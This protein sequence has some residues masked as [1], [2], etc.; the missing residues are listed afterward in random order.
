[1]WLE[2]VLI[3]DE[4]LNA[5]GRV[6][7]M[8]YRASYSPASRLFTLLD[9][10]Q[11]R[12]GVSAARLAER[13]EVEARSVRRYI[14]MLQDMGIPVEG[15]RGRYGGYRLC[16]SYK[17]PPLM[18]T[19]EEALAVTLGLQAAKQLGMSDAIPT[20]ESALAK[21]ER[22][23]PQALRERIQAAQATVALDLAARSRGG[24]SALVLQLGVAA[25]RGQRVWMRY[26]GHSGEAREREFDCYGLVYHGERWYAV[27]YCHLRQSTRVF[28]LDR[29]AAL[30]EREERFT[31]PP[32]F[33]CLAYAIQSFAAIPSRWLSEV[34]LQ[35]DLDSVREA[36]PAAFATLE[37]TA[38]GV[39][40][41]AYD[42]DLEHM[43]RFL[44]GLGCPFR[45]V[46]PPELAEA[47]RALAMRL[48]AMTEIGED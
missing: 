7:V 22:V 10:L 42:D 12:P 46:R 37:E 21:V 15:A 9:M 23:L 11:S 6:D 38:D 27:G 40:L 47:V 5:L 26:R 4:F 30:E 2:T 31:A 25:R 39:L 16:P 19:E 45:I 41:R 34:L 43:T 14:T 48:L 1:M 44:V 36:V 8:D 13:L 32:D 28:R 17:L 3:S 33:D 20:V 24:Q 29:I 18:W 35:T